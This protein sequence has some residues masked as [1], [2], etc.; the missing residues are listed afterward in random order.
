MGIG[1]T[2][3]KAYKAKTNS[4]NFMKLGENM[5]QMT[6]NKHAKIHGDRTIGGA[7][8]VQKV[9]KTHIL[10]GKWPQIG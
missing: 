4:Q 10:Y 5:W 1:Q 9:S 8:T 6:L 3:P 2:Y 7:I